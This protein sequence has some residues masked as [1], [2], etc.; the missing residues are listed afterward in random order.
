MCRGLPLSIPACPPRERYQA[1]PTSSQIQNTKYKIW[2]S[3][4]V[5]FTLA[6]QP[7][8]TNPLSK[9]PLHQATHQLTNQII[10]NQ[11]NLEW[12]QQFRKNLVCYIL[13]QQRPILNQ[14]PKNSKEG[15]RAFRVKSLVGPHYEKMYSIYSI[16]GLGT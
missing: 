15:P 7:S 4:W 6:A 16:R 11:T 8:R 10:K 2:R 14:D 5:D 13:N 9:H 3:K 1:A 12:R